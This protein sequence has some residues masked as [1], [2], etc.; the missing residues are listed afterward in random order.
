MRPSAKS[1]PTLKPSSGPKFRTQATARLSDGWRR[2]TSSF[3]PEV[4]RQARALRAATLEC[5]LAW[6]FRW[7]SDRVLVCLIGLASMVM[8]GQGNS[9]SLAAPMGSDRPPHLLQSTD[10][11]YMP[12]Q[13]NVYPH[14]PGLSFWETCHP[15]CCSNIECHLN[16]QITAKPCSC[17]SGRAKHLGSYTCDL[18]W[19]MGQGSRPILNVALPLQQASQQRDIPWQKEPCDKRHG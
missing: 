18:Q 8:S 3:H 17:E 14:F 7:L 12:L 6:Q 5:H 19:W 16:K 11:N 9:R 15:C 1:K 13:P 2:P 10:K 4:P